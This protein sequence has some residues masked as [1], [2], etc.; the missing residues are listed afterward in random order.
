MENHETK[1]KSVNIGGENIVGVTPSC[2][3][4]FSTTSMM[5]R[6]LSNP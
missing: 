2:S 6:Y 1:K 3:S 4:N 5:K